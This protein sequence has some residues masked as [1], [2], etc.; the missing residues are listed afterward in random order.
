MADP[1]AAL[2][3]RVRQHPEDWTN[4]LVFADWLTEQGDPR[5][6]LIGLEHRR[7]LT[8]ID[9]HEKESLWQ[10]ITTLIKKHRH[11]WSATPL[12][13]NCI[14]DWR[15]GFILGARVDWDEEGFEA[16]AHLL[17]HE[18]TR[19]LTR[20]QLRFS[21]PLNDEI[22]DETY[23]EDYQPPSIDPSHIEKLFDFDLKQ[24]RM[25][26]LSYNQLGDQGLSIAVQNLRFDALT[27]LDLR[28][29]GIGDTAMNAL[30]SSPW[31]S[32]LTTLHLHGN[33]IGPEGV[34]ALAQSTLLNHHIELIDLRE[35]P[36]GIMGARALADSERLRKLEILRIH[37]NDI[38]TAGARALS[39]SKYLPLRIRRYW[40]AWRHDHA[41]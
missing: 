24:I 26:D 16:L 29:T 33:R 1:Q 7:A 10:Q 18:D 4:W 19:L 32:T 34:R 21:R 5:G 3:D 41:S 23:D 28:Y 6:E 31:L 30:S 27:A 36:I 37:R 20:L 2:L 9:A 22:F 40:A 17:A 8:S 12:P 13:A 25:L 35:N 38:G 14:L 15:C 11:E 39:T